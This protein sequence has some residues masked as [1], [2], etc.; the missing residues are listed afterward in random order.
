MRTNEEAPKSLPDD[1]DGDPTPDSPLFPLLPSVQI[2]FAAFC[3]ALIE[4]L[5]SRIAAT[6]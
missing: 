6:I 3:R 1:H 4:A 2:F 5:H